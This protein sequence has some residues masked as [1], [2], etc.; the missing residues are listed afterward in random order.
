M[1]I[2]ANRVVGLIDS[3]WFIGGHP[4]L[5]VAYLMNHR[6][7][8]AGEAKRGFF[9]SYGAADMDGGHDLLVF[10]LYHLVGKLLHS[11]RRNASRSRRARFWSR[12]CCLVAFIDTR[13]R[14][15]WRSRG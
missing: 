9:A 4:L 1:V 13:T 11:V 2:D 10:R 14:T 5:D 6:R 15:T 3:G 12:P 8:G 7:L